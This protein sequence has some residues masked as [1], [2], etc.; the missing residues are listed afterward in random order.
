LPEEDRVRLRFR[1]LVGSVLLLLVGAIPHLATGAADKDT[2]VIAL[3]TLGAQVMDPILDTRAPH[4]HY[5]APIWDSL[6]GFD[7]EKG[8]IGPGAAERWERG[9]DG[10]SWT[11]FLRKGQRFHN[12]D[13]VTAHDVKFSLE[14][15]MLP[16]SLSSGAA[17]LRRAVDRIEVLDDLTVRVHTKGVIPHFA[18][19]LSRAV[20]MEGTLMP[21]NY[22]EKVG[23]KTFRERPIGSGPW[24]FVRNVPG[25]RIEYEAVDYPHWRGTPQ[26]KRMTLLLVPEQ[27]TRLAMVRTGEASIASIGPEAL[28]EVRAGGMKAVTVPGTMQAVYQFWGLYRPEVKAS[29]LTDVRV[30]EALSLA[31]DRQ[32]IIDHVMLGE[33]RMPL[34]FTVY[35]Y[36]IDVTIPRWEDWSKTALR[37]DPARAKKLLAEAGHANGFRLTFWNTAL[38]GT[39]FMVQIGEAVAGFWEKLGVKVDMKGVEWGV[40][41][42]MGRGEQKGLVG[43]ASM[44]RTAGRPEPSPRY[45]TTLNSKGVQHLFGDP[46]NCPALCQEADK[47]Y[48]AVVSERDDARRTAATNRMIEVAANSWVVVPIVEGMGYWAVNPKRVGFFKPIPGRHEFGDVAERMPRPEQRPWP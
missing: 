32:Q 43:T 1:I 16:D 23:A 28:K 38:P 21:K 33:A 40:F 25:D 29:P 18:A 17:A 11:F 22:I 37:Y 34:P 3:D 5:Q 20:F 19:S 15:I 47:A 4:A 45:I 39:P 7:L 41:D 31:I 46:D 2:L 13:P 36:S 27:S 8:G 26:F 14:R 12:G 10:K 48:E 6:V 9:A 24:K 35:R 30:R 42:P 44:Y